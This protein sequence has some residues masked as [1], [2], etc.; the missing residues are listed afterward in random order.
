MKPP[1]NPAARGFTLME[2]LVSMTLMSI[3]ALAV[4]FGFRIGFNAW[5]KSENAME[6]TRRVHIALDLLSRQI[7]SLVPCY[8]KQKAE[9]TPLDLPVYQGVTNGMRFVSTFSAL[10]RGAGGAR[11]VEYFL[12]P[13][14]DDQT[15]TFWVNE[16]ELP[17]DTVLSDWM[18][19]SISRET[20]GSPLV[21]FKEFVRQPEAIPLIE[22]LKTA[23]FRY[24]ER[25]HSDA[26]AGAVESP[27]LTTSKSPWPAGVEIKLR[28]S[29]NGFFNREDF[30]IVVPVQTDFV[31]KML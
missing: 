20:D 6:K 31:K 21:A 22:N 25:L 15:I 5:N 8:T 3:L 4:F 1:R 29:G 18:F 24:L 26:P 2:L 13:S 11:L 17:G 19:A 9:E 16:R 30:V 12:T 27:Q 10:Y 14:A 28:W 7:G 23:E